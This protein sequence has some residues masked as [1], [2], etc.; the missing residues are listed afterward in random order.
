[1]LKLSTFLW[2]KHSGPSWQWR[3]DYCSTRKI[4]F[5]KNVKDSPSYS[6]RVPD[7][8][9]IY[10]CCSHVYI[11]DDLQNSVAATKSGG[12]SHFCGK[13]ESSDRS[14]K[15]T[16]KI[17]YVERVEIDVSLVRLELNTISTLPEFKTLMVFT[18]GPIHCEVANSFPRNSTGWPRSCF[19]WCYAEAA[20]RVP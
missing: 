18:Y 1:M 13:P 8:E 14:G 19:Q 4:N 3:I 6:W 11:F 12:P 17:K 7:P 16:H 5:C 15:I 9:N 10:I 2:T 20:N